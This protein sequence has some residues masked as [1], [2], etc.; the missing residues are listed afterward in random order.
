MDTVKTLLSRVRRVASF[1]HRSSV[2]NSTLKAK[3]ALLQLPP[4]KL[5]M[6][7]ST[8]WNS[9]NAMVLRY[10]DQQASVV[11]ILVEPY[12]RKILTNGLTLSEN[13]IANLESLVLILKPL[14]SVKTVLCDEKL[15][16]VSLIHPVKLKIISQ[17]A[18][19]QDNT[20][21]TSSVKQDTLPNLQKRYTDPVI[22]EFFIL[23]A[24]L[25]ARFECLTQLTMEKRNAIFNFMVDKAMVFSEKKV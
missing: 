19:S 9:S 13:D 17:L 7:V 4:H 6:N 10:I 15:P 1:F 24:A 18:P 8:R 21:L 14:I 25:D 5:I 23:S 2:A 3:E 11:A 12:V 16:I 20:T 22:E